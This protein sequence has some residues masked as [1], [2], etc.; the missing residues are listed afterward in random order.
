MKG[1]G[2][3]RTKQI[4]ILMFVLMAIPLISSMTLDN[5]L[6]YQ[7]K[8]G[9]S[10]KVATINNLLGLERIGD[11]ELMSPITNNYVLAGKNRAVMEYQFSSDF[12]E[13]SDCVINKVDIENMKTGQLTD[14]NAH[15][16]KAIY[17][18]VP[19]YVQVCT[20]ITNEN[21]EGQSCE[22][23]QQG[24]YIGIVGW[25]DIRGDY[26]IQS[27]DRIR[28]VVDVYSGDYMDGKWTI[29]GVKID[30]HATWT[31]GLNIGLLA[32]WNYENSTAGQT[33]VTDVLGKN[34]LTS[35]AGFTYNVGEVGQGGNYSSS[36]STNPSAS[37]N[38][39]SGNFTISFWSYIDKQVNYGGLIAFGSSSN[40]NYTE[41][42]KGIHIGKL[43]LLTSKTGEDWTINDVWAAGINSTQTWYHIIL[44]RNDTGLYQ[45]TNTTQKYFSS[46]LGTNSTKLGSNRIIIGKRADATGTNISGRIDEVYIWNRSLSASERSDLYN[47]GAGITYQATPLGLSIVTTLVNPDD[48]Y[49]TGDTNFNFYATS[50]ISGG[51]LTNM[52]LY[53]YN[54]GGSLYFNETNITT[55]NTINQ[56]NFTSV[57]VT[58]LG[59]YK[60]NVYTCGFNATSKVCVF[61]NTN[62][63]FTLTGFTKNSQSFNTSTYEGFNESYRLN[64]SYSGVTYTFANAT[65]VYGGVSYPTTSYGGSGESRFESDRII[66]TTSGQNNS[67]Y[68]AIYLNGV[69]SGNSETYYQYTNPIFFSLCNESN[70]VTYL[71]FTFKDSTTLSSI[72]AVVPSLT[73]NYY[74]NGLSK[75]LPYSSLV[76][77]PSYAFCFNPTF[78]SINYNVSMTYSSTG[79]PQRSYTTSGILSN[80]TTNT[81]LDL[82]PSTIGIYTT[83]QVLTAA[84]QTLGGVSVTAEEQNLTGSYNTIGSGTTDSSGSI[85]FWVNPLN[86]HRFTFS[87]SSYETSIQIIYP[88]QTLYT[89]TLTSAGSPPPIN[90]YEG[91]TSSITPTGTTLMNNTAYNFQYNISSTIL[92]ITDFGFVLYN[93][94]GATLGSVNALTN[95]GSVTL[96]LNTNNES[97]INMNYYYVI[98]N[99]YTN[100]S[101]SWYVSSLSVGEIG[102]DAFFSHLKTYMAG[103]LFGLTSFGLGLIIFVTIFLIVGFANIKFGLTSTLGMSLLT[104]FLI[105]LFDI[106]GLLDGINP[107]G[108]IPHFPSFFVALVVIIINFKEITT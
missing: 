1:K 3:Q 102:V 22:M 45:F 71:N 100:S 73:L 92:T 103:G 65:L 47:S 44:M 32:G 42:N 60:W 56:T 15:F 38:I 85:T 105:L 67:L 14:R 97:L 48:A 17:G 29:C 52:T 106:L 77:T 88:T 33:S 81:I 62:R 24:N 87:K 61:A 9:I 34:N 10:N 12:K 74:L 53:I 78:K 96:N 104:F 108:A 72:N 2:N 86:L 50:S 7:S 49:S 35:E 99:T 89:L 64:I 80:S 6:S 11:V 59:N 90:F 40:Y 43:N 107:I 20:P 98:N 54:S 79:Y 36:N 57:S 27:N 69:I 8:D 91:I 70:N 21:G 94:T 101:R 82:L 30:K 37:F 5:T 25:E 76:E 13:S 16:E 41:L 95:G 55:G 26:I 39:S 75:T 66:P 83:F 19:N 68:W 51:N 18:D 31:D 84:E 46:A 58:T 4:L 63:T 23:K 28:L 93:S